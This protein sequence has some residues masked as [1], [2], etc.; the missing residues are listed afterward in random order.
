M[1]RIFKVGAC[2]HITNKQSEIVTDP[3][4]RTP[5]SGGTMVS[6]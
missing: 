2:G 6:A 4:I 1:K 5:F 3:F